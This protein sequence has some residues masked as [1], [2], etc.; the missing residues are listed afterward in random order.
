MTKSED[1]YL[2]Y[3]KYVGPSVEDGLL[4]ARKAAT[5]LLGLDES[6]RHFLA[7]HGMTFDFEIPVRIKKGSW[8]ALIPNSIATWSLTA[9]GAA[10]TAFAVTAANTM[11]AND[12]KNVSVGDLIKKALRKIQAGVKIAKYRGFKMGTRVEGVRW[13]NN[14]Q[15]I[16][17]PGPDGSFL[18]VTKEELDAYT[19]IPPHLLAKLASVVDEGR[20]LKIGVNEDGNIREVD[21]PENVKALFYSE[22]PD[23]ELFPELVD[24]TEVEIEGKFT[25]GNARTNSLGVEYKESVLTCH[26]SN[27]NVTQYKKF[28]FLKCK[29]KG[30]VTRQYPRHEHERKPHIIINSVIALEVDPNQ[31]ELL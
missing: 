15:I 17:I 23:E 5:A 19:E 9:I 27:G 24:G 21:V 11:A 2:G 25:R 18:D 4:D 13:K 26:P 7:Q 8:E 10:A 16:S 1:D 22:S 3:F 28:L 12:F 20:T 29:V 6:L 31:L 30:T 14:N